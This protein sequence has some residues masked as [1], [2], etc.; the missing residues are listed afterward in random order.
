MNSRLARSISMF[1]IVPVRV[2]VDLQPGEG[3]G[4]L[5]WLP[6]VGAFVGAAAALPASAIRE[7][8]PHA[9]LLGRA[10]R[11]G[12]RATDPVPASGRAGR[13]RPTA[14]QRRAAWHG[15]WKS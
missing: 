7:W 3:T 8:A 15:R 2:A 5:L 11:R 12:A 13:T 14:W 6:A 9:N 10:R 4:A 1:T